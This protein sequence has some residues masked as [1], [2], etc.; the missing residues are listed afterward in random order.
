MCRSIEEKSKGG[1]VT[2]PFFLVI[3]YSVP[4]KMEDLVCSLLWFLMKNY[5]IYCVPFVNEAGRKVFYSM[6]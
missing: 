1:R 2:L 5:H 3:Q 4:E 6:F